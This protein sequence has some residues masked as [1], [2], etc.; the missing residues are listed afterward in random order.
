MIA[1]GFGSC[2]T[3]VHV[4]AQHP[5]VAMMIGV[6]GTVVYLSGGA[7]PGYRT[8]NQKS[9]SVLAQQ[10]K[11]ETEDSQIRE[12]FNVV[13]NDEAPISDGVVKEMIRKCGCDM[14]VET[15]KSDKHLLRDT[16]FLYFLDLAHTSGITEAQQT[17]KSE[18][19][20]SA[21]GLMSGK[22]RR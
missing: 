6:V 9:I 8:G 16:A 14:T 13:W 17:F 3:L 15:V 21:G 4:I 7:G 20:V 19:T 12:A 2:S 22:N 11:T 5:K 1:G 18:L 10:V